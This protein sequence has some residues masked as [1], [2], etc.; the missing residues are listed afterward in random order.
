VLNLPNTSVSLIQVV[1][2]HV[3]TPK[4]IPELG[5]VCPM[6]NPLKVIRMDVVGTFRATFRLPIADT[7]DESNEKICEF[8]PA[9]S[10]TVKMNRDVRVSPI[11]GLHNIDVP[12]NQSDA[13]SA[14]LLRMERLVLSKQ[15]KELPTTVRLSVTTVVGRFIETILLACTS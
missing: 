2:S 1:V 12:D 10:P 7:C 6:L 5:C 11:I 4:R 8:D 15:W 9:F 14:V 13:A 3:D